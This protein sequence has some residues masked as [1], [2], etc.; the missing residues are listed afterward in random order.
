ML[1]EADNTSNSRAATAEPTG[2]L[3]YGIRQISAYLGVSPRQ[4]LYLTEKQAFPFWR[5]GRV[6]CARRGTIQS[7]MTERERGARRG[8]GA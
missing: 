7:W 3:L 4:A 2:E 6:I 5:E 8:G 1:P